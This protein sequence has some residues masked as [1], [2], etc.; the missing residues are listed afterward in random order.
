MMHE[1]RSHAKGV[2]DLWS[3]HVQSRRQRSTSRTKSSRSDHRVHHV[4]NTPAQGKFVRGAS[5][6]AEDSDSDVSTVEPNSASSSTSSLFGWVPFLGK[7][8]HSSTAGRTASGAH[9]SKV[10]EQANEKEKKPQS[11]ELQQEAKGRSRSKNSTMRIDIGSQNV[12][13]RKPWAQ[14]ETGQD[15]HL[16]LPLEDDVVAIAVFD[17][18]GPEGHKAADFARQQFA[19]ALAQLRICGITDEVQSLTDMFD[20]TQQALRFRSWARNSGTTATIALVDPIRRKMTCAHVGDSTLIVA[21]HGKVAFAT[22]D[23]SFNV[24]EEYDRALAMGGKVQETRGPGHVSI[25]RV[26]GL[27]VSRTLGDLEA[28][29]VGA[30]SAPEVHKDV[31]LSMGSTILLASDGL[32][33]QVGHA[34]ALEMI[35][36]ASSSET[37]ARALVAEAYPRWLE[38]GP[39]IDDITAIVVR[40]R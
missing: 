29:V 20:K 34:D 40:A 32:W 19:E 21:N 4:T 5:P 9:P 1:L 37:A 25:R 38:H 7:G 28:H 18:H 10:T 11:E 30:S 36:P 3:G 23:H 22:R 6:S 33:N 15:V 13:G 2:K 27:A 14:K 31:P 24:S 35:A 12:R 8:Q 16:V 26:C 39:Y 17:G